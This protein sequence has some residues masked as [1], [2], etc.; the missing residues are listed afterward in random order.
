MH[1][2]NQHDEYQQQY[3]SILM[4]EK[5]ETIMQKPKKLAATK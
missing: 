2:P 4:Y 1:T 5:P 3:D